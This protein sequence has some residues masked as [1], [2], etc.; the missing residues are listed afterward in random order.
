MTWLNWNVI[1]KLHSN[2]LISIIYIYMSSFLCIDAKV[3]LLKLVK[4]F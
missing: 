1:F 4:A 2:P 3:S